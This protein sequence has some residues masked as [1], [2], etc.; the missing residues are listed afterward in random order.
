M[1]CPSDTFHTLSWVLGEAACEV[2]IPSWEL[3]GQEQEQEGLRKEVRFGVVVKGMMWVSVKS[4]RGEM[5]EYSEGQMK[6]TRKKM[7]K[8][9]DERQRALKTMKELKALVEVV[10]GRMR[11]KKIVQEGSPT[12]TEMLREL[13]ERWAENVMEHSVTMKMMTRRM[14][15]EGVKK[16]S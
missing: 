7:P 2:L 14:K 9:V 15:E 4:W 6:K 10:M 5:Q 12:G 1:Q 8:M 16:R 13:I 11:M 3:L